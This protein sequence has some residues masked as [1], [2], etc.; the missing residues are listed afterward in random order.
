VCYVVCYVQ[1]VEPQSPKSSFLPCSW[2][3]PSARLQE[4]S[5]EGK[6]LGSQSRACRPGGPSEGDFRV[7]S[8]S[9]ASLTEEGDE[10]L[11]G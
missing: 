4:A 11:Q 5:Q 3:W 7:M 6:P 2:P 8:L 9:F 10:A 1:A